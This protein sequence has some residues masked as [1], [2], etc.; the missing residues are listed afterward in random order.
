M[1]EPRSRVFGEVRLA[2]NSGALALLLV[3]LA[4]SAGVVVLLPLHG[5]EGSVV[6]AAG[7]IAS[8]AIV[9]V[10][11][12]MVRLGAHSRLVATQLEAI[13]NNAPYAITVVSLKDG[14]YLRVNQAFLQETGLTEEKAVTL[15]Y[16]DV[17]SPHAREAADAARDALLRGEP[18]RNLE[19][20]TVH[21]D[22]VRHILLSGV[23][24]R[25][26][27]EPCAILVTNNVTERRQA[28]EARRAI[29]TRY[30]R[31]HESLQDGFAATDLECRVIECNRAFQSLLGY[32][33]AEL[34][35][36]DFRAFTAPRWHSIEL[37]YLK[38]V[39]ERGYSDVYEK[40]YIRKD[41]TIVPVQLRTYLE[42]NESG[43][44]VGYWAIVTDMTERLRA[45]EELRRN[46]RRLALAVRATSDA[47]WEWNLDTDETYF[48]PRWYEMLGYPPGHTP[49]RFAAF[50]EL[51]HPDDLE[52]T[53]R[54][55]RRLLEQ[56]GHGHYEAEFRMRAADGSWRWILGRG[57]VV[58]FTAD[59][60]PLLLAGTNTDVT[61]RVEGERALRAS[62]E[63]KTVL[64]KEVHHRV[65]NNLQIVASLMNLQADRTHNE[66]AIATLHEMRDRVR[67]MAL[68]HEALYRS[69]NLA[70][71][72]FPAY[73]HTV[74]AQLTRSLG[75]R[76]SAAIHVAT[77]PITLDLDRAV[78]CGLIVNELV[79]NAYKHAFPDGRT[80][81]IHVG[82]FKDGGDGLE[83]RVSDDG[84]G[85][86]PEAHA[87]RPDS[88]GLRLVA[89]LTDKLEGTLTASGPPGADFR[90]RFPA[91]SR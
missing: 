28:E 36:M 21:G 31:L 75:Q 39:Q 55:V 84:I 86:P 3:I 52:P 64:L 49:M 88:L 45:A 17:V 6:I 54:K 73:I 10:Y 57:N 81:T 82:L 14:R 53:L 42:S 60:R 9:G 90:I 29:A 35:G 68:L 67:S 11:W 27:G 48:S 56:P 37:E 30:R 34:R 76:T 58:E 18:L 50:E 25:L 12:L 72:D 61:A 32:T 4:A 51:C 65:K 70:Q 24:L 62:L 71:V 33:E 79:S 13:Y 80:G 66:D 40:E 1:A 19:L 89:M 20:T 78:S 41:G 22:R 91:R 2:W 77:E 43:K 23:P 63:E 59:G 15:T 16:H 26:E 8:L 69:P 5:R 87:A 85:L 83:L 74:A 7:V 38:L 44:P 47:I 46:E